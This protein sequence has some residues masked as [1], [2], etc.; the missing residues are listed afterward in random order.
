M[1]LPKRIEALP[2]LPFDHHWAD[3]LIDLKPGGERN[4]IKFVEAA[5]LHPDAIR[6][7]AFNRS[8]R[9][10]DIR[11]LHRIIIMRGEH[12]ALARRAVI[13]TELFAQYRIADT[14]LQISF[15]DGLYLRQF[16][17][18]HIDDRGGK[19]C[20]AGR[21]FGAVTHFVDFGR[22]IAER[23]FIFVGIFEIGAWHDPL[24]RTQEMG[25][26]ARNLRY[27]ADDLHASRA[28]AYHPNAFT[29]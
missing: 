6:L 17:R 24:R 19:A 11:P 4:H 20:A 12:H 8:R 18:I 21:G 26:L 23:R 2:P 16:G 25:E 1:L 29:L 14:L 28:I 22:V 15:A 13:G 5:I 27:S 9:N 3:E 7:N 10:I